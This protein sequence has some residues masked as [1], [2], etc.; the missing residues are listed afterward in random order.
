MTN[1]ARKYEDKQQQQ[2]QQKR[3]ENEQEKKIYIYPSFCIS[4]EIFLSKKSTKIQPTENE[5]IL[6]E[7]ILN[8]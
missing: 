3:N 7:M 8:E 4:E 2:Q 5:N 1:L 6:Y